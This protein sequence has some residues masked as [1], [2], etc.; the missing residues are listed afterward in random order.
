VPPHLVDTRDCLTFKR[1]CLRCKVL[2]LGSAEVDG[3]MEPRSV[4]SDTNCFCNANRVYRPIVRLLN[5]T[6]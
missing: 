1:V 6:K 5:S 2:Y 3:C 4:L